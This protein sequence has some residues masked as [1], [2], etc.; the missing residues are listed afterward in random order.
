MPTLA[1]G[2]D[3]RKATV[4]AEQA[5]KAIRKVRTETKQLDIAQKK[6]AAT[7][8]RT[9]AASKTM[10]LGMKGM[11]AG[12]G[13]LAG[14][15]KIVRTIGSLEESMARLQGVTGRTSSQM[16]GLTATARS[17]GAATSFTASEAADGML[18]LARSGMAATEVMAAAGPVLDMAKVAGIGLQESAT[19]VADSLKQFGMNAGQAREAADTL[20]LASN[21]SNTSIMQLGEGLK[22]AGPLA[23]AAGMSLA[24]TTAML[25]ILADNGMKAS[26]G[27]TGVRAMLASLTGPSTEAADALSRLG[28]D[29]GTLAAK[30]QTS[31]GLLDVMSKLGPETMDMAD[32]IQIFSRRGAAAALVLAGQTKRW[33]GLTDAVSDANGT[34]R[35][36][37]AL[38]ENTMGDAFKQLMS[39]VEEAIHSFGESGFAGA[40]KSLVHWLTEGIRTLTDWSTGVTRSAAAAA[41]FIATLAGGAALAGLAK[42]SRALW[43]IVRGPMA[44]I[45]AHPIMAAVSAVM[46]LVEGFILLTSRA[47]FSSKAVVDFNRAL[48]DM[49]ITTES[50]VNQWKVFDELG[51]QQMFKGRVNVLGAMKGNIHE[52]MAD[53]MAVRKSGGSI[54][55]DKLRSMGEGLKAV[56]VRPKAI[57][58]GT[59]PA[60]AEGKKVRADVLIEE[61]KRISGVLDIRMR[62]AQASV[63]AT[64]P[65]GIPDLPPEKSNQQVQD[66]R[67][68]KVLKLLGESTKVLTDES[69]LLDI[70]LKKGVEARRAEEFVMGEQ[71][72][73]LK[74]T[75]IPLHYMQIA[76]LK[77]L[78][79]ANQKVIGQIDKKTEQA[80]EQAEFAGTLARGIIDP[81]IQGLQDG[82]FKAVGQAMYQNLMSAILEEMVAKPAV[83]ALKTFLTSSMAAQGAADGGAWSGGVQRFA[84]GGV[85]SSAASFGLAGGR[86]GVMGEAGPEAIMPLKRLASGK[87]G[88]QAQGGGSTI[89]D[90]RTI[91][92]QVRDDASFR[93][94]LRQID[95][96]QAQQ[97]SKVSR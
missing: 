23:N 39:S 8:N 9:G 30:V 62:T 91:N 75:G 32:A 53:L 94:T 82:D 63:K 93:R 15:T 26:L 1:I 73:M 70:E 34:V 60:D 4:G 90:N 37:A 22:M 74:S 79:D 96:D 78:Y 43:A 33:R 87:L 25:G 65:M 46:L 55:S 51:G 54:E 17:L 7:M 31:G 5:K 10:G 16:K 19:L 2:I 77:E 97:L 89:N 59:Q 3:S 81:L 52:L 47:T 48:K 18:M 35:D 95:R 14:L 12:V 27:G 24:D 58:M 88:V 92:I 21:L 76:A 28:I 80:T 45:K 50:L 42:F 13:V 66:A 69:K 44:A 64:A 6:L 49:D 36:G 72:A 85:V 41:A 11:M 61:L 29:L 83:A 84:R 68:A 86:T 40:I 67:Y 57:M 71:A 38:I 20:A 56:G